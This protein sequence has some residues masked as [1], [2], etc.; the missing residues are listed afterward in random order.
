MLGIWYFNTEADNRADDRKQIWKKENH[1]LS[2]QDF[3]AN[4]QNQ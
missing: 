3:E 1:F 2:F 4:I